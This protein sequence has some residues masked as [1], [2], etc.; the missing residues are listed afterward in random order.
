MVTGAFTTYV[1]RRFSTYVPNITQILA[2]ESR[3]QDRGDGWVMHSTF[4]DRAPVIQIRHGVV[5][6]LDTDS[7]HTMSLDTLGETIARSQRALARYARGERGV[8]EES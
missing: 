3:R 2:G 8:I 6:A 5:H 1:Q 7:E 4:L